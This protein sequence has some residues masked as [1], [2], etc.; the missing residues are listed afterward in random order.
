MFFPEDT[1]DFH[2][3]GVLTPNQIIFETNQFIELSQLSGHT[4][5]RIITG[6]GKVVR[7][8]VQKVIS[9]HKSIAKFK[10][11]GYYD[12]QDGAFDIN[13]KAK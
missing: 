5:V 6:K 10:V 2:D 12:G 3:L 8:L 1:L 9:N 13:L 11:A 7:P 4:K